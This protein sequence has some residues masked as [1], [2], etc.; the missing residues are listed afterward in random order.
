MKLVKYLFICLLIIGLGISSW[1]YYPKYEMDQMKKHAAEV[2]HDASHVSYLNYFR[3][4][5]KKEIV[6]L[7]IGDSVIRGVG[8][9]QNENLVSQFSNKLAQQIH[10]KIQFQNEGINGITSSELKTLVQAGR[11][12]EE[13]KKSDIVTINVGGNDILRMA[14]R[15]SFQ[16]VFQAFH[17]LQTTFSENLSDIAA[18]IKKL[19][20]NATIVFLELYNPLSPNDQVYQLADQLL[21]KWN[22]KIYEVANQYPLSMVVETTKVINGEQRQNL[23]PDGVHPNSSGYTAIS[24]QMIYQ[25]KHQYRKQ[26][27]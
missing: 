26:S 15:Q 19:N 3:N 11:F 13:I 10:K 12:D 9:S 7:A 23:A 14:K 20:P 16:N 1:L 4:A 18:R 6:H 17:Q 8:A 21:P 5:K 25:F 24:E 27:V 22:V 2:S